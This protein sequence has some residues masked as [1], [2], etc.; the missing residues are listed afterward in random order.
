MLKQSFVLSLSALLFIS[1]EVETNIDENTDEVSETL[2]IEGEYECSGE[3]IITKDGE[4][5]VITVSSETDVVESYPEAKEPLYQVKISGADNFHELEIGA[6]SGAELHTA[7]AE[8]S[9]STYPVLEKYIFD[10]DDSGNVIGFTKIVRNPT[11]ENFKSCVIYGKKVT[12]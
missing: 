1:C 3:C 6:L 11:N 9:D 4:R 2:D 10:T 7:T 12:K 8:V 5:S